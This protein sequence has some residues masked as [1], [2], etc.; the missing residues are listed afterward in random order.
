MH[1]SSDIARRVT[2]LALSCVIIAGALSMSC[3]ALPA[4]SQS[5]AASQ[6]TECAVAGTGISDRDT[7]AATAL[8]DAVERGPL[9]L[10]AAKSGVASC[11][12]TH[13][14]DEVTVEYKFRDGGW[15]RVAHQPKLEYTDQEVRFATPLAEDPIALL[16]GAEQ[17]AFPPKGCGIDWRQEDTQPADDDANAR[18]SIYRGDVCNCQ[19]RVRR[20]PAGRVMGLLLR[21]AC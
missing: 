18:E 15:L 16:T 11:Q 5:A 21:S 8:R 13:E 3:S 19:G 2:E 6:G 1:S 4:E 17:K 14:P 10:S 9:Y 20:D 12:V 7:Q